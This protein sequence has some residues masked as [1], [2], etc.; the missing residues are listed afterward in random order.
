MKTRVSGRGQTKLSWQTK[1]ALA[2]VLI[3]TSFAWQGQTVKAETTDSAVVAV[4]QTE[5]KT[6]A[7]LTATAEQENGSESEATPE[8]NSSKENS[9]EEKG[10]AQEAT[11]EDS[12]SEQENTS[13][14]KSSEQ[15][16][17][18][19]E[20]S[21][22]EKSSETDSSKEA[23]TP[24]NSD[25]KKEEQ[26][27]SAEKAVKNTD[28]SIVYGDKDKIPDDKLKTKV[29]EI[30]DED[31]GEVLDRQT[32]Y[33][34][35]EPDD[36]VYV[37]NVKRFFGYNLV[38]SYGLDFDSFWRDWELKFDD[39]NALIKIPV[40]QKDWQPE[41]VD[42]WYSN[43]YCRLHAV[44]NDNNVDPALFLQ[45]SGLMPKG[46]KVSWSVA[47]DWDSLGSY[48][49]PILNNPD[50]IAM[51]VEIPGQD[52]VTIKGTDND[53][54]LNNALTALALDYPDSEFTNV[55]VTQLGELQNADK[56]VIK[57]GEFLDEL[58]IW[59][60]KPNVGRAGFSYGWIA[61]NVDDGYHYYN[62]SI[63]YNKTMVIVRTD[64]L[65]VK[66]QINYVDEDGNQLA[67]TG[68]DG[69]I[70]SLYT[71]PDSFK[72]SDLASL[73]DGHIPAGYEIADGFSYPGD[74]VY[75]KDLK[76]IVVKL[77]KQNSNNP[78][79][80]QK[81]PEDKP[82]TPEEK[83]STPEDK[84][85]TTEQPVVPEIPEVPAEPADP[86]IPA[87][88]EDPETPVEPGMP[89][90]PLAPTENA[91][92]AEPVKVAKKAQAAPQAAKLPQ[93]GDKASSL[94]Q[95]LGLVSLAAAGLLGLF[96]T[97]KRNKQ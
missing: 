72:A 55:I 17:T 94:A 97:K 37:N 13:D 3:G 62:P 65:S 93:T 39:E 59:G 95:V 78:T 76:P 56:L 81:D 61:L 91:H 51:L 25:D 84:P 83:P 85:T 41:V 7:A 21:S 79:D 47:P 14:E 44:S 26:D 18:P 29:L 27:S 12:N 66:Q 20:K 82:T 96:L 22:E 80:P 9:S 57:P 6:E 89:V 38:S 32:F 10:S 28:Y 92:V 86:E 33:F 77:V 5:P 75:S 40:S 50:K 36:D 71:V 24:N 74:I 67:S 68:A 90:S 54:R 43:T 49:S 58:P 53:N 4:S 70:Y 63:D 64:P 48:T 45:K 19:E 88:P 60:I 31:T 34:G 87:V 11:T 69:K 30:Y 23:A 8:E 46:T 35:G 73:I 42:S 1:V 2:S 16:A 15:E 52:P